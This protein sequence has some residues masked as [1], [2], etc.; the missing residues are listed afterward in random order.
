M[1]SKGKNL[2]DGKQMLPE[3]K[4]KSPLK[5]YSLVF[6]PKIKTKQKKHQNQV[7]INYYETKCM[8]QKSF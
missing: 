4:Y 6:L 3:M 8:S 2:E 5:D 1:A 7:T